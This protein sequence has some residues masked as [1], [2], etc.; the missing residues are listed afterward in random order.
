MAEPRVSLLTQVYGQPGMLKTFT[1]SLRGWPT[2]MAREAELVV[3]DD[4]GD[5]PVDPEEVGGLGP[6]GVQLLRHTED[7]PWA[8]P[9]CRNLA[10]RHARGERLILLDPDMVIPPERAKH[11]MLEAT[12]IPRGHVTRFCLREVNHPNKKH[13]GRINTSSPN[14]WIMH[15]ADFLAVHGYN[16]RFAGHKGWSDVEL[17]HVLDSAY[18][19]RQDRDLTVDFY[20]RSGLHVDADVRGL[21]REVKTN[22]VEHAANRET[23]RRKYGGNWHKWR[24]TQ[25]PTDRKIPFQ[26]VI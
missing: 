10:V 21:D 9:C 25:G 14:A 1:D 18:K 4:C 3:V 11:F 24:M 15:K 13:R 22:L 8:Q 17:L 7:V 2:D 20:R 26:R 19:V 5:P 6:M 23:V 16:E 12:M